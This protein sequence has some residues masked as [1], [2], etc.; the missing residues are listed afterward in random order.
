MTRLNENPGLPQSA[1][2]GAYRCEAQQGQALVE[3]A[4]A[5]P[6]Q[7]LIMFAIMQLA[8][9][10]V[11]KQV[12][13]YASYSAARAAMVASDADDAYARAW[14]AAA[15][16][17]SPITGTTVEG[18]NFASGELQSAG[19]MI[20]VP[21]WGLVPKS[22]ISQH[23]KTNISELAFSDSGEVTVTVTHYY[24]LMFPVVNY[25]FSWLAGERRAAQP[26]PDAFGPGGTEALSGDL[27]FEQRVGIWGADAPH[28]RLRSTTTLPIPGSEARLALR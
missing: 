28:M 19:A 5:F 12:V 22:G 18:S 9:V 14:Q 13:N 17:C 23:L 2:Q 25:A 20:D 6:L 7:L 24:E 3:F 21:G 26:A 8:L 27:L 1:R 16:V 10:Y 4:F 11:G 15:I